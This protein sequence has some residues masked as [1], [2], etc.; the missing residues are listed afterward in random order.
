MDPIFIK[1]S[2]DKKEP[3]FLKSEIEQVV[4]SLKTA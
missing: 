2:N 3:E 1:D 4:Q